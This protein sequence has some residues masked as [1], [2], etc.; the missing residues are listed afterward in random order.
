[1]SRSYP[2]KPIFG[3]GAIVFEDDA[4][5]LVKRGR[6]PGKGRWSLPGGTVKLG[7]SARQALHREVKEET[8]LEVEIVKLVT[9]VD[10]IDVDDAGKVRHHYAVADYRCAPKGGKPKAGGDAAEARWVPLKDLQKYP[11]T[12]K[13]VEVITRAWKS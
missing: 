13:A 12:P 3:V 4:V 2:T 9:L 5:L 11:L 10:I 7:E 8:G 6:E 1:M